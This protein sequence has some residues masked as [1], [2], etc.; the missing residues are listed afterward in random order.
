MLHEP[1]CSPQTKD[2]RDGS[3]EDCQHV[4]NLEGLK[5]LLHASW[6]K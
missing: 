1:A 2:A 5:S 3:L 4:I 6:T